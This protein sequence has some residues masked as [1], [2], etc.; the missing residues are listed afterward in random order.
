MDAPPPGLCPSPHPPDA[1]PSRQ[2]VVNRTCCGPEL[3]HLKFV[4]DGIWTTDPSSPEED[5]GS[6]NI[7]N[8]LYPHQIQPDSAPA[9]HP[10]AAIMSGVTPES[11]TA[12]LAGKVPRELGDTTISSAAPGS[13]S[14]GLAKNVPYEQ[15]SAVPGTFPDTPRDGGDAQQFSVNPIPASSGSGNP[16]HLKPGEKVPDPSTFNPNT[17]QSTVRT[18]PAAY[19]QDASAPLTGGSATFAGASTLPP[20]SQSQHMIPESSLP[21]GSESLGSDPV[22][23]QSAAPD[24]T[25]AALAAGVPPEPRHRTTTGGGPVSEVPAVVR[26]SISDAHKDPEAAAYEDAVDEKREVEQELQRK[27]TRDESGGTPAPTVTAAT[28]ATAPGKRTGEAADPETV[29]PSSSYPAT[30]PTVTSGPRT[31]STPAVSQPSHQA[32]PTGTSST[33]QTGPSERLSGAQAQQS[34]G[35]QAQ[36]PTGAQAQQPTSAQAQQPTGAQTQQPTSAQA[37]QPTGTQAQQ[38]TGQTNQA[39]GAGTNGTTGKDAVQEGAKKK[40]R[41]FFSKLKEKFK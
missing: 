38:T 28:S 30:G 22:T 35:S 13:T 2:R 15:R 29:S 21:M 7:N 40:K 25:T 37:Q 23:I 39:G 16:I 31:D 11:T 33:Q 36:Q 34:A 20:P 27:V 17:V 18:D 5:D 3:T 19:Y 9:S 8:V 4:V 24:S 14:T 1:S 26:R 12:G 6:N 41:G 32:G 10:N